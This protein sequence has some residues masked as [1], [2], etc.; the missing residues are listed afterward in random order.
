MT[1]DT[2]CPLWNEE[3]ETFLKSSVLNEVVPEGKKLQMLYSGTRDGFEPDD[4]HERCD[5]QESTVFVVRTQYDRV[6]GGYTSIPWT[7][8]GGQY[9]DNTAFL[10]SVTDQRKYN[11]KENMTAVYHLDNEGPS[12]FDVWFQ[13]DFNDN[14]QYDRLGKHFGLETP[15]YGGGDL[16]CTG[17]ENLGRFQGEFEYFKSIELYVYKVVGDCGCSDGQFCSY[18]Q[19][20]LEGTCQ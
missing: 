10:F 13:A 17:T 18:D 16:C 6:F 4:F 7:K 11:I 9:Q 15:G 2:M 1:N 14:I 12:F 3:Q 8:T 5:N 20:D 19:N